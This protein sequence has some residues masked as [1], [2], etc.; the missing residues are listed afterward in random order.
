M[1]SMTIGIAT[2]PAM[3]TPVSLA[4]GKAIK[5]AAPSGTYSTTFA[6]NEGEPKVD[7]R[8]TIGLRL[9]P[10]PPPAS[11][12]RVT[13]A[14]GIEEMPRMAPENIAL[15][16]EEDQPVQHPRQNAMAASAMTVAREASEKSR[17]AV[18]RNIFTCSV[19]R[20]YWFSDCQGMLLIST[21]DVICTPAARRS[22]TSLRAT[23]PG[24]PT[25]RR[26]PAIIRPSRRAQ[27]CPG[28]V[29]PDAAHMSCPKQQVLPSC[30]VTVGE[31]PRTE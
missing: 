21:T 19:G 18:S 29:P 24:R 17:R 25:A 22:R 30:P 8:P 6:I 1:I 4:L 23:R 13:R 7:P 10:E 27:R 14:T 11:G 31:P 9:I 26:R 3:S 2:A 12:V 20:P 16:R 28:D 15:R 5:R